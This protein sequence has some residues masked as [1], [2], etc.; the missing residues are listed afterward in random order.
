MYGMQKAYARLVE[1][2]HDEPDEDERTLIR[3]EM[4][5][6]RRWFAEV[7]ELCDAMTDEAILAIRRAPRVPE[8]H[9]RQWP[10]T[11]TPTYQPRPHLMYREPH[12]GHET[13][14]WR[15]TWHCMGR[16]SVGSRYPDHGD[17]VWARVE[18]GYGIDAQALRGFRFTT[19]HTTIADPLCLSLTFHYKDGGGAMGATVLDILDRGATEQAEA[20]AAVA[21]RWHGNDMRS[22]CD[23]MPLAYD[24]E[25][26]P[27]YDRPSPSKNQRCTVTEI[28][29]GHVW[30]HEPLPQSVVDQIV[31][32]P[33]DWPGKEVG[34]DDRTILD[35]HV[36]TWDE[37]YSREG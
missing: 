4:I 2:L 5:R 36:A 25:G 20:I 19:D 24:V 22:R 37:V 14:I 8:D 15:R 23:C 16:T 12:H 6:H 29:C 30:W 26:A 28:P 35:A 11:V 33:R 31:G 17:Y 1:R 13:A 7:A 10:W 9:Q 3:A 27:P 32:W 18:L 21:R 34:S